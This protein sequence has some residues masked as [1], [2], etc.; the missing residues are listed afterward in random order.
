M[1]GQMMDRQLLLAT[2][3]WRAEH[4]FGDK[5]VVTRTDRDLHRYTYRDFGSRVRR[6]ANALAALGVRPGDRVG[7]LAWNTH[8]H[9][10]A[11]YA[12]PSMG[13]V[14][15]T[16][17]LRLTADQIA[18][19]INHAGDTVLLLDAD[20]VERVAELQPTIPGVKAFVVLSE[21]VPDTSLGPLFSYEDLLSQAAPTLDFPELD[22]DTASG[23][24]YTSATTGDPKG[25]VYS[26]RSMVLHSLALAV[27]GSIGIREDMTLVLLTPMFHVNA[28]GIP[29]AAVMQGTKLVLPGVH[30]EPRHYLE[31]IE[32]ERVTHAVGAVTIGIMLRD[33][34]AAEP[35]RYD[36][37]SLEVLWLGGQAPPAGLIDWFDEHHGVRVVQGWGMT[38][39][40]PLLTF[41]HVKA[42]WRR[43][44]TEVVRDVLSRQGIPVPGAEVKVVDEQG[45]PLPWDG[46]AIGEFMVRAPWVAS[47]Y[48]DDPERS[49]AAFSDGWFRTGDMGVVDP[50]GY[51]R[52]V[53]RAKDLIKSGGEWISS[54]DLE[55]TLMAHP[56]VKE[57]TV[58]GVP[59]PKWLER[60]VACIVAK[61]P[62]NP[63]SPLELD[64]YLAERV[65]RWWLPDQYLVLVDI[66]K[67]GVGKF[68]KKLLRQRY[69]DVLQGNDTPGQ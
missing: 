47:S 4:V 68:D 15:H 8:R 18:Y 14:L 26:H 37:S 24:C 49:E 11:Y 54:V 1:K 58:I 34:L 62:D 44:G 42:K 63:P 69:V 67:T 17:N 60:P 19:T 51:L 21:G 53:D 9:L 33:I 55:N 30:P 64:A 41:S 16:V 25:V 5:E 29:H 35:G 38:E 46:Q 57:A 7:S 27:H 20:Q 28:W 2:Q 65:P 31:V 48:L 45:E 52:L 66:P 10:E 12:V 61:D 22:E 39:A 6:L 50:D 36:V 40:S 3:L 32:A 13:A 56:Q 59:D 23:I 43:Q